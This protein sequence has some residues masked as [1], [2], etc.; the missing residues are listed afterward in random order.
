MPPRLSSSVVVVAVR[1]GLD[2]RKEIEPLPPLSPEDSTCPKPPQL[3]PPT[4]SSKVRS[5][6][7]RRCH[8]V[9]P[10][11]ETGGIPTTTT[12]PDLG[13]TATRFVTRQLYPDH[14]IGHKLRPLELVVAKLLYVER[15]SDSI[16]TI[17]Q[18]LSHDP[19]SCL[20]RM[21]C[22]PEHII[23]IWVV[24]ELVVFGCSTTPADPVAVN[25]IPLF[26]T[27]RSRRRL[28]HSALLHQQ[29]SSPSL[30]FRS[31]PPVD[32]VASAIPLCSTSRSRRHLCHFALLHKQIPSPDLPF[33]SAP[34]ADPVAASA[35][36]LCSTSRSRR[37]FYH[38]TMLHQQIP[39]PTLP[40]CSASVDPT[41]ASAILLCSTSKSRRRLCH[42]A[43]LHKQ[44]LSSP[45]SFCCA[46]Q[47]DPAS[48]ILCC[49]TSRSRRRICHS[50]L[51]NQLD[52]KNAFLNDILEKK[53]VW[54][55]AR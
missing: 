10:T 26:Y 6:D 25:A 52:V 53:V 15:R 12:S 41:V 50:A 33:C 1:S 24:W 54:M 31:A 13:P 18:P 20:C 23:S 38:S 42:S 48:A 3:Q 4:S 34:Q 49:Y 21:I 9:T 8:E 47:A 39:S 22:I 37:R 28:C 44:I 17:Q 14:D 35:I 27:S 7:C 40:F 46:P 11:R 30:P 5:V 2:L 51:L 32:L 29:I 19:V 36:L 55:Q 45:L 16:I 43:L